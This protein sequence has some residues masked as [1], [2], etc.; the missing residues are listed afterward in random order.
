MP[1]FCVLIKLFGH[2]KEESGAAGEAVFVTLYDIRI[3]DVTREV[4]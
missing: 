1:S 2:K 3:L 4:T